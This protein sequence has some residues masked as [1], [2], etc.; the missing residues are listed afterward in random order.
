MVSLCYACGSCDN[1]C[2]VN[3]R[4]GQL[5]PRKIVRAYVL[6]YKDET[7]FLPDVWYCIQCGQCGN[8]CPMNVKPFEV[9]RDLRDRLAQK[10]PEIY[11]G[12]FRQLQELKK[13]FHKIRYFVFDKVLNRAI[14]EQEIAEY[15]SEWE[16]LDLPTEIIKE[17][18]ESLLLKASGNIVLADKPFLKYFDFPTNIRSC[19]SCGSCTNACPVSVNTKL[20][21]PMRIFRMVRWGTLEEI[22]SDPAVWLCID[23]GRCVNVCPQKVKGLWIL[24]VIREHAVS[25]ELVDSGFV[26]LWKAVDQHLYKEYCKAITRVCQSLV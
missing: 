16:R 1:E 24:R 14:E 6:G 25:T 19:L 26:S 17:S 18:K 8:V 7:L 21:S 20:F 15:V 3:R 4:T 9:I 22:I 11:Q 5:S 23:C 12:V 10:K 13:K 2:P